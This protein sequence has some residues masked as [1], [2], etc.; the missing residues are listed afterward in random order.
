MIPSLSFQRVDY[1]APRDADAV[2]NFA[3]DDDA[4]GAAQ[5]FYNVAH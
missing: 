2:R 3:R 1:D 5:I 4:L